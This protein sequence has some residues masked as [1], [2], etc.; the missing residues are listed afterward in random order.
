MNETKNGAVIVFNGVDIQ[1]L[2]RAQLLEALRIG[3]DELVALRLALTEEGRA[4]AERE[5]DFQRNLRA[6]H[7]YF[8]T[9]AEYQSRIMASSTAYNQLIIFAGY[10]AFFGVWSAVKSD[11][12]RWILLGSG[13]AMLISLIIFIGWTVFGMYQLQTDNLKTLKTFS[14]GVDGFEDR[15]RAALASGL[16]DTGWINRF[17]K[18]VVIASGSIGFVAASL[19]SY[20]TLASIFSIKELK[21]SQTGTV[22]EPASLKP[23]SSRTPAIL[24]K[25]SK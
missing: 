18:W 13:A 9:I 2:P 7:D 6:Q 3:D 21:A 10:A 23:K 14:E 1:T 4:E 19:L 20:G 17:W 11:I 16:Q 24:P 5:E 8:G 22:A 15:Y 12:S 25:P